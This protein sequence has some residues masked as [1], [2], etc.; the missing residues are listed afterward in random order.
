MLRKRK[1]ACVARGADPSTGQM[2]ILDGDE[3]EGFGRW[4]W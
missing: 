2:K 1:M 3:R 4:R